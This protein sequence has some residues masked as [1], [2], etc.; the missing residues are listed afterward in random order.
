MRTRAACK[1][2]ASNTVLSHQTDL[3]HTLTRSNLNLRATRRILLSSSSVALSHHACVRLVM[4]LP[5]LIDIL[6]ALWYSGTQPPT[7]LQLPIT[8]LFWEKP[9]DFKIFPPFVFFSTAAVICLYFL[10]YIF[11]CLFKSGYDVIAS[12]NYV[13]EGAKS[14]EMLKFAIGS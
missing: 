7:F 13:K 12:S 4:R 14:H 9:C 6:V 10:L 8:H 2:I 3:A 5:S 11:L 1:S